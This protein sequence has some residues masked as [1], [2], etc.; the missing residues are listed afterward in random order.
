MQVATRLISKGA[1]AIALHALCNAID[2]DFGKPPPSDAPGRP[3]SALT[4]RPDQ[5]RLI[6][7]PYTL[8]LVNV[9]HVLT[10]PG[11]A[12]DLPLKG[13]ATPELQAACRAQLV[14]L[15]LPT[16]RRLRA[17]RGRCKHAGLEVLSE[18]T[19]GFG[20]TEASVRKELGV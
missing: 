7:R 11:P 3:C 8:W 9:V 10:C 1:L 19:D 6:S 5:Q 20:I 13:A 12:C 16:L 4:R 18:F 14:R 15:Y 2:E 17:T